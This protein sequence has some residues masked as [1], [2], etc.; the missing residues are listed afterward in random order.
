[1][2][3]GSGICAQ[4]GFAAE[5]T[6]GTPVTVTKFLKHTEAAGDGLR[7]ITVDDQGLGGCYD[8]PTVDRTVTTGSDAQRQV[9]LNVASKQFGLW[10]KQM[11]G[12]SATATIIS[13]GPLYRQIHTQGD[14]AG[15]SLTVQFSF[16]ETTATGTNRAFTYKGC[17]VTE[18]EL[19]QRRNDFLKLQATIDAWG[20]DTATG[21]AAAAYPSPTTPNFNELFRWNCFSAKIGGTASV[22]SGL[23]S[24]SGG[25]EIKGC[26]G[27]TV[28]GG[29]N[30][31]TDA[32]YSGGNGVKSE[33]LR[34]DFFEFTGDLDLDFADRTQVYDLFA[35]YTTTVLEFSWIGKQ[36][37][38]S[39][40]FAKLSLIFPQVKLQK[41][42]PNAGGPGAVEQPVSWKAYADPAGVLP[43]IQI[44][45]DSTD[46]AL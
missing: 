5:S 9:T 11:V 20:E 17:K 10:W 36:D 43:V 1:M 14:L 24:V 33:Q 37:V 41:G 4:F 27:V 31:R 22:A 29:L 34:N 25:A 3:V 15:K 39:G 32:F 40:Q 45:Y 7:L 21:L 16:P 13:S 19:S 44:Q 18:W 6:V 8:A 38:G 2:T 23:T 42:S 46:T 30:L 12:S 26:K 35:A 28:K